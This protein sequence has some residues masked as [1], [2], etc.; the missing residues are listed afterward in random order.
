MG[1]DHLQLNLIDT[2][3]MKRVIVEQVEERFVVE[4]DEDVVMVEQKDLK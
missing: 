3:L 2:C 1:D 4:N